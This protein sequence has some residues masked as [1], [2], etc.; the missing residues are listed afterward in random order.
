MK[1]YAVKNR[2]GKYYKSR[3]YGG[4]GTH[5][6]DSIERAKIYTKI[7]GARAVITY[8]ATAYPSY[9]T[10]LLVE[11][12]ATETAVSDESERVRAASEKKAERLHRRKVK[13]A[14]VA[15]SRATEHATALKRGGR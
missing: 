9:G 1:L 8:W 15:A 6:V 4:Y 5:W 3:G 11:L 12:T 7:G 13:A 14:E 10:P 2:E